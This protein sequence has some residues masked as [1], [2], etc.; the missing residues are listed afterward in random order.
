V[1]K[2]L[3]ETYTAAEINDFEIGSPSIDTIEKMM[4]EGELRAT[5]LRKMLQE[6]GITIEDGD[7]EEARELANKADSEKIEQIEQALK[8]PVL[9][10]VKARSDAKINSFRKKI[11]V[12]DGATYI[13]DDMCENLLKQVGAYGEDIQ[14]AFKVLRGEEVNGRVYTTKD[15]REML[16]AYNLIYTTVIGTQ[17]Y[18]AYGFRKQNGILIP[19]YNKTALF[20]LFKALASG[21]TAK[22]YSKMKKDGVDMVM[23][24]SAVKVGSQGS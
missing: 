1:F 4:Y 8:G 17:K 19:Y 22:L 11:N 14:R 16:T 24:N 21:N 7:S 5:Y 15:T 23:M 2:D 3:P 18:T 12:A 20:P 6:V 9:D 10:T 13:T